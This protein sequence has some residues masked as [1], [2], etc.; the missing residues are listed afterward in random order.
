MVGCAGR[1]TE[2]K[3]MPVPVHERETESEAAETAPEEKTETSVIRE[4][5]TTNPIKEA[6]V[7]KKAAAT[8]APAGDGTLETVGT[9]TAAKDTSAAEKPETGT[10][11]TGTA[12]EDKTT[13]ANAENETVKAGEMW[14]ETGSQPEQPKKETEVKPAMEESHS[15]E[16]TETKQTEARPQQVAE[17]QPEMTR[18][19]DGEKER[20]CFG[21]GW[22]AGAEGG[23][24]FAESTF[25]SFGAGGA[26]AGG[27]G[28]LFAGYRFS[29]WLSLEVF[30]GLGGARM[31]ARE[32]CSEANLWLSKDG[33]QFRAAVLGKEGGYYG[34][35]ESSVFLQ[36][37]GL[38]LNFDILALIPATKDGKWSLELA[39]A[40]SA[41]GSK[42]KTRTAAAKEAIF[43]ADN[44]QLGLG[45]RVQAG[46][47]VLPWMNA[48]VFTGLT[49]G[50]GRHIDAIPADG[51]KSNFTWESG[52][53][54]TFSIP[55]KTSKKSGR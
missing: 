4:S 52:V 34:E 45:G 25:S 53:R 11:E 20:S 35:L 50:T 37:Y 18:K 32:C 16:E 22:Y 43:N 12:A 8:E 14:S 15:N 9:A 23:L 5:D 7:A 40:V 39:P 46:Y 51:H 36:N 17:T 3:T 31:T 19:T 1:G 24:A 33:E 48:G 41:L 10:I 2:D 44:W 29:G 42:A 47:D 49:F 13:E 21:K 27:S 26:H 54:L 28:S 6:D 38:R 30:A 55:D